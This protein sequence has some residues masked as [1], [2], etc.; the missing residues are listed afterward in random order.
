MW[1]LVDAVSKLGVPGDMV[2]DI[3]LEL[4]DLPQKEEIKKRWQEKQQGQSQQAQAQQELELAKLNRI[5]NTISFK[6]APMPIQMA[7]AAKDGLVD[8][9]FA[10]YLMDQLIHEQ[11]PQFAQQMDKQQFQAQ[12]QQA[13][14]GQG[15]PPQ[16]QQSQPNQGQGQPPKTTQ[17][18]IES[19]INGQGAAV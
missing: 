11:Y 13:Q 6:D 12:Q 10:K 2:F 17:A 8:P 14:G 16:A 19:Y 7:M 1:G 9:N 4:S 3:I 15:P 18:A 5:N